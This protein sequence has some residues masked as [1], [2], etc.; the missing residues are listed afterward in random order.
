MTAILFSII[1]FSI[2]VF[3]VQI[4]MYNNYLREKNSRTSNDSDRLRSAGTIRIAA[5]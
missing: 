4:T 3:A 5:N 1:L 2:I